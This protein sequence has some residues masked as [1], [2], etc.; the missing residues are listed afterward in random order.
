MFERG[1]DGRLQV[2]AAASLL[3]FSR[4][5][6]WEEASAKFS[7]VPSDS[8]EFLWQKEVDR[9]FGRLICW[10][11]F[12]AGAEFLAKGVCL[13]RDVEIRELQKGATYFGT[14]GNL[15]KSPNGALRQLC[16]KVNASDD[17]RKLL[18]GTYEYLARE[19][20]N[21]DAHAYVPNVRRAHV[22]DVRDRFV[23]CFNLLIS[24]LP[25]GPCVINEW[26]DDAP[27]FIATL[28]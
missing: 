4:L 2:I 22:D 8:F 5:I 25:A 28:T 26:R 9:V 10:I 6:E 16:A 24:W 7:A 17:Q 3:K 27:E 14:L 20:R 13:L 11:N 15:N 19:I 12:S 1:I 23:P 21:R 18:L